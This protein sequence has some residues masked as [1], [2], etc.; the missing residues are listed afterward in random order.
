MSPILRLEYACTNAEME[1]AQTV[2]LRKQLG[3]GSKWR[4]RL[5]FLVL[6]V[7]MLL[8]ARIQQGKSDWHG[9]ESGYWP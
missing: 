8:G 4:T 3:R 5:V 6:L 1:Q 2:H 7:G 9:I